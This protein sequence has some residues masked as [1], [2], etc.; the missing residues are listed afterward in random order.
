MKAKLRYII[1][2]CILVCVLVLI[3]VFAGKNKKNEDNLP[4]NSSVFTDS[5]SSIV[6]ASDSDKTG[7][8]PENTESSSSAETPQSYIEDGQDVIIDMSEELF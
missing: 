3:F 4:S 1:L 6:D 8:L 2:V 5:S 7:V